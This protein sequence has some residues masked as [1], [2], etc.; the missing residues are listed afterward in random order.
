V[1]RI[2]GIH[3]KPHHLAYFEREGIAPAPVA[4]LR[5]QML[6]MTPARDFATFF[7]RLVM[8]AP[9]VIHAIRGLVAGRSVLLDQ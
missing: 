4:D 3:V 6:F 1:R 8:L 2:L 5:G 7:Q 9:V